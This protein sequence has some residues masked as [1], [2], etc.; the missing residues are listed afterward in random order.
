MR[1][2]SIEF[3][4]QLRVCLEARGKERPLANRQLF[5]G[6]LWVQG[7]MQGLEILP[8]ASRLRLQLEVQRDELGKAILVACCS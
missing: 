2:T 4:V 6:E 1:L 3:L 8:F 5:F 7:C